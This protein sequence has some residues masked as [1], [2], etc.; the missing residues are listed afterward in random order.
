[1]IFITWAT[2]NLEIKVIE[3]LLKKVAAAEIAALVR[4]ES[5]AQDLTEK[6]I[7]IRVGDY[8]NKAA[9]D[10]AMVGVDKILLVSGGRA[11]NGLEQ[12]QNVIDAAGVKTLAYTS[13]CLQNPETISNQLMRRNFNGRVHP[14]PPA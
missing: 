3:A 13:R 12:H 9:L 6:G 2:G 14:F 10:Q 11:A 5:K 8:D 7:T 1:M 4:D